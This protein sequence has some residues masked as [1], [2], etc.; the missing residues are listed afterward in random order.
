MFLPGCSF[1]SR[2][3]VTKSLPSTSVEFCHASTESSVVETTYLR[4]PF[5]KSAPSTSSPCSGQKPAN[6]CQVTRPSSIPSESAI[7]LPTTAPISSLK[8]GKCHFSGDS[9]TPS[10]DRNT[11]ETILRM[12]AP[13]VLT[14]ALNCDDSPTR[15]PELS[16][17]QN[18]S[19][20]RQ[21]AHLPLVHSGGAVDQHREERGSAARVEED[22]V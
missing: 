17:Q 11:L 1:S 2:M 19:V 14:S 20:M 7:W 3:A 10:R 22:A 15:S 16:R 4:A 21:G 13:R 8:Y 18:L 6:S 9:M 12:M 5:M